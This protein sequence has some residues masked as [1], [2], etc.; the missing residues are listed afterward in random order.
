MD[1][2]M[3]QH[4]I[5]QLR[6]LGDF[7]V[8]AAYAFGVIFIVMGTML[9]PAAAQ[10]MNSTSWFGRQ[11]TPQTVMAMYI[12]GVLLIALMLTM[13]FGG[14]I[15]IDGGFEAYGEHPL[16]WHQQDMGNTP[17]EVMRTLIMTIFRVIGVSII[18][19]AIMAIRKIPSPDTNSPTPGSIMIRALTG[20][21][22]LIPDKASQGAANMLPFLTPVA[23]MF[24]AGDFSGL[25]FN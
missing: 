4:F 18:V 13:D 21:I 25:G 22:M 8:I 10:P 14:G 12:S 11:I 15:L 24:N 23:R 3:A 20:F 1:F 19:L 5:K 6:Y 9:I 2:D 17:V 7:I 16:N